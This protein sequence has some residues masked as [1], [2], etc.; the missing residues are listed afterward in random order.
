MSERD[1]NALRER[2]RRGDARALV[3]LGRRLLTGDGLPQAAQEGVA[4]IEAAAARADGEA[5]AQLAV[6]DAWGVLRARN[7]ASALDRLQRAAELG[8]AP[9]QRELRL[10]AGADGDDWAALRGRVDTLRWTTPPTVRVLSAAPFI[11]ACEGFATREE[12]AWLIGLGRAGL[13]RA[14]I[15]RKEAAGHVASDVRTNRDSDYTIWRVDVVLSLLRDRLAAA[16]GRDTRHFEIAKLLH[17]EPGQQFTP[18]CDFQE[19]NTPALRDEV[20]R[21][22]QRVA[23]ALVYLNDDYEGGETEFPR[24]ALRYKGACGDALLFDNVRP[25]GELDYDTLHAGLPPTRG[26]KWLFS[27]WIR[28]LPVA[29]G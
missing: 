11:R 6:F 7:L 19:P 17:Y 24:I 26:E 3:G 15:Y 13:R 2:A 29:Q 18:H 20:Q 21:H 5:Q 22:G 16:A 14:L 28:A 1:L 10:L 27:Q 25:S 8:W 4:C 12:C 23:T 9:A